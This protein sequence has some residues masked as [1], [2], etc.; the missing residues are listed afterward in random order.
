LASKPAASG[1][2]KAPGTLSGKLPASIPHAYALVEG[3]GIGQWYA[4]KLTNVTYEAH[5]HLEPSARTE[6]ATFGIE[7]IKLAMDRRHHQ[8]KWGA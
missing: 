3:P 1:A 8:R 2:E 5:E 6:A 7:R 4:V